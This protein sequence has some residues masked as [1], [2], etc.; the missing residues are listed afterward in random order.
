MKMKKNGQSTLE[1]VII[2]S[3]IVAAVIV[4][5]TLVGDA[6]NN[7]INQSAGAMNSSVN[8]LANLTD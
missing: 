1:Y 3:A 4:G 5:K 6:V 2:L 7:T 8:K